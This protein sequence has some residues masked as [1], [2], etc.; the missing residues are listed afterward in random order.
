MLS[1]GSGSRKT[2]IVVAILV[3]TIAAIFRYAEYARTSGLHSDFGAVWF[4]ATSLLH[5]VNPYPLVGPGRSFDWDYYLNYPATAMVAVLPLALLSELHATLIFVWLTMAAMTYAMTGD[6]WQRIWVIPSAA[7]IVAARAA[8]WSPLFCAAFFI[9]ALGL[10]LSA[11]PTLGVV[12]FARDPSRGV[13][14]YAI[15]GT[16]VLGAISLALMPAWPLEWFRNLQLNEFKPAFMWP[17]GFFTLLA[18]LRWRQ[19]EGRLLLAMSL[20][21]LT[22]SWYEA[23]PLLF[24]GRTKREYQVLSLISSAGY[25]AQGFFSP[26]FQYVP[27]RFTKVLILAFC[28]LPALIVVLRRQDLKKVQR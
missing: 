27:V 15:I 25:I 13:L 26:N 17:F 4:G 28:Y 8:Q 12:V 24:V 23:L 18:A 11:K 21:P 10:V 16:V 22:P 2:R 6:G 3:G 20:V 19:P 5:H 7:F 14:V 1:I 9:P